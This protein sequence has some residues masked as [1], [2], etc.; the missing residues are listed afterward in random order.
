MP[1]FISDAS[2]SSDLCREIESVRRFECHGPL[3]M[4]APIFDRTLSDGTAF[5]LDAENAIVIS[6]AIYPILQIS[7]ERFDCEWCLCVCLPAVGL[8]E[9]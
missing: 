9:R 4:Q 1:D 3:T 2:L 7:G 5:S 6:C 8:T